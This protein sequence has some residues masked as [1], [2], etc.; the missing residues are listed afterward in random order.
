MGTARSSI[1]PSCRNV[2]SIGIQ[3]GERKTGCLMDKRITPARVASTKPNGDLGL[4]LASRRVS[5]FGIGFGRAFGHQATGPARASFSEPAVKRLRFKQNRENE[6][7][8]LFV[9]NKLP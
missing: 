4:F 2:S 6:A 5:D 8:S 9:F 1:P 7:I 3:K